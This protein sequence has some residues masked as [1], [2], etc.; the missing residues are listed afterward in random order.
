VHGV[1]SVRGAYARNDPLLF[2]ILLVVSLGKY[3]ASCEAHKLPGDVISME[4]F[5][6]WNSGGNGITVVT[7]C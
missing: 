4:L 2:G 7:R 6:P 1:D 3:V 5:K